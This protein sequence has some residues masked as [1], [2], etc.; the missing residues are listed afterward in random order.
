MKDF[1][2]ENYIARLKEIKDINKRKDTPHSYNKNNT[3]KITT[4]PKT[5]YGF[6]ATPY[7]NSTSLFCNSQKSYGLENLNSQRNT[8]K[9]K[10]N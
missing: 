1:H 7:Q 10:E 2:P 6:N 9:E 8:E 5:I 4:L 3:I